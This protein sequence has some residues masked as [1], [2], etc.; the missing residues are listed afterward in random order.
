MTELSLPSS[1]W[2]ATAAPAADTP[3]LVGERRADAVVVG[4]GFTGKRWGASA[5]SASP[6]PC[7]PR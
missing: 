4:G 5:S 7:C 6:A 1:Q 2:A 3:A